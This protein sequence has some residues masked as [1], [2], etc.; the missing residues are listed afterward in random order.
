[1]FLLQINLQCLDR[2]SQISRPLSRQ[3]QADGGHIGDREGGTLTRVD[4]TTNDRITEPVCE[5]PAELVVDGAFVWVVCE[6]SGE[7]ALVDASTLEVVRTE[8]VGPRPVSIMKLDQ[9]LWIVLAES[10]EVVRVDL[11]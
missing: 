10:D 6:L 1:L 2:D 8:A 11:T 4:L 5:G 3:C 7:L 9:S